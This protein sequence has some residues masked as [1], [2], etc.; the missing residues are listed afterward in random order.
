MTAARPPSGNSHLIGFVFGV[1]LLLFSVSSGPRP[2]LAA[3]LHV[4]LALLGLCALL[5][6]LGRKRADVR[7]GAFLSGVGMLGVLA[8]APS[9]QNPVVIG[10]M[11]TAPRLV[12]L[13][14]DNAHPHQS[15]AGHAAHSNAASVPVAAPVMRDN[16]DADTVFQFVLLFP[17]GTSAQAIEQLRANV[18]K[19]VYV[20]ACVRNL[21]CVSRLLRLSE[22]GAAKHEAL[23]FDLMAET[24]MF[25]RAALMA[26]LKSHPL[27]PGVY[28]RMSARQASTITKP[29][30]Q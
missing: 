22:L 16:V 12:P 4:T 9:T 8:F 6:V 23:T 19:R 3:H 7:V 11:V 30:S 17:A 14:P 25:E 10:S 15:A 27:K 20:Q 21:P 1:A 13:T 18:L 29:T 5:M 24:P 2:W 28:E 26:A